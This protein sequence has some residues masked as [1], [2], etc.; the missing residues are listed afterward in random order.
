MLHWVP[1]TDPGRTCAQ[2][3]MRVS[4]PTLSLSTRANGW[5]KK[6]VTARGSVSHTEVVDI[7]RFDLVGTPGSPTIDH[8]SHIVGS[9]LAEIGE[10]KGSVSGAQ[11]HSGWEC[12]IDSRW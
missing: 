1:I 10:Q 8:D 5:A 7:R 9:P 4:E 11:D 6:S 2:A 12:A 3:Q